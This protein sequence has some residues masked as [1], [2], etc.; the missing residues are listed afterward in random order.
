LD[1]CS[2]FH[3]SYYRVALQ[4]NVV[5][6]TT[7][8]DF[9]YEHYRKG[10]A[11]KVHSAQ[12]RF[13]V[14]RSDGIICVSENTKRDLLNLY[15][16]TPDENIRVIYNG[17]GEEF[18]IDAQAESKLETICADLAVRQYILFVGDRINYKNFDVALEVLS[19]LPNYK[20][21][22]IGGQHLNGAEK[23]KLAPLGLRVVHLR[24][25]SSETLNILYNGALCLLY[26]SAYE[27]FGI[28]VLEAMKAGCPVVS[29]NSSSIPEVAGDAALLV[30][31]ISPEQ[32][33]EKIALLENDVFRNGCV[34]R[35][36]V[37]AAAFSWD[38]CFSE[39]LA[40]YKELHKKKFA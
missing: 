15:P 4:K 16:E 12:K 18:F 7:V 39:T 8:H 23:Q 28:P 26:P 21:V 11:R 37:N 9:T 2:I 32:I 40:F 3:S 25:V 10:L 34:G 29:T 19:R 24:G 22:I 27:G 30:D 33:L 14:L 20:F 35:G 6:V 1:D 5:N 38:K 31:V 17:V 36:L 13:A